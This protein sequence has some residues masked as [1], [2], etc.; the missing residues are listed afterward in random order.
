[1]D[2]AS[3][4]A[5]RIAEEEDPTS[6]PVV[7]T[8]DGEYLIC[9]HGD[10][11]GASSYFAVRYDG[12]EKRVLNLEPQVMII[13]WITSAETP[14]SSAASSGGDLLTLLRAALA[15]ETKLPQAASLFLSL[16]EVRAMDDATLTVQWTEQLLQAGWQLPMSGVQVVR[17]SEDTTLMKL[18]SAK[19][20][21]FWPGGWQ[22]L[23]DGD[24]IQAVRQVGDEMG[25]I[26]ASV[27]A[28]S[29]TP[30]FV[31]A[32][33]QPNTGWEGIWAPMDQRE[34]ICTDGTISF[35]NEDLSVLEVVGTSFALDRGENLVFSE[36][37]AC[38][39]RTLRGIWERKGDGY[40]RRSRLPADAPLYQRLWEMTEPSPYASLYEFLRRLR[41]GDLAG[42]LELGS[43]AAIRQAVDLGL[44][45]PDL[46]LIAENAEGPQVIFY[47]QE[48]IQRL[49]AELTQR[50]GTWY[51]QTIVKL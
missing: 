30:A 18:P 17:A 12:G 24:I 38:P 48:A 40:V 1:M 20:Y 36:C 4:S 5:M 14:S 31:L 50:D 6:G 26:F 28:G 45:N 33:R 8:P 21:A 35:V 11:E 13:G 3:M 25:L 7:W 10:P 9:Y 34:W 49:R 27:G 2:T 43:D 15:D 29:V 16:S 39:H 47:T 22:Y 32:R 37:H 51:V 44:D 46:L 41:S 23:V 19:I 42:A